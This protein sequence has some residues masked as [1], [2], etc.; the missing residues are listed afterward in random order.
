M[1]KVGADLGSRY[2]IQI[3][4]A[5]SVVKLAASD[6]GSKRAGSSW[7]SVVKTNSPNRCDLVYL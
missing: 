4:N 1:Q 5:I 7:S 6:Q 2:E 3:P